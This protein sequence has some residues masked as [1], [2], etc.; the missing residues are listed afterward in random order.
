MSK[1]ITCAGKGQWTAATS[2]FSRDALIIEWLQY[3]MLLVGNGGV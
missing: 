1:K 3:L 2:E